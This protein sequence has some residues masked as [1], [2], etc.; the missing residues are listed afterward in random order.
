MDGP[1]VGETMSTEQ[2][3]FVLHGLRDLWGAWHW[4]GVRHEIHLWFLTL[5]CVYLLWRLETK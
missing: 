5:V 3:L 2:Y 1:G 4:L